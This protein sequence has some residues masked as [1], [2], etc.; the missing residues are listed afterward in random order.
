MSTIAG[1][2]AGIVLKVAVAGDDEPAACVGK[3]GSKGSGLAEIAAK[4]D[5]P[6]PRVLRLQFGQERERV[7]A[8]AVIDRR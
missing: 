6:Q 4:A 2:S 1:M 3:S 8:A 5:H 7:I